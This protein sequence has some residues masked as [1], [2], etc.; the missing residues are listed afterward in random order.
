MSKILYTAQA[1]V[2]GGRFNGH[3]VTSDGELEVDIRIPKDLGG[4]GEGTNPEQLFA[5]GYASCFENAV[6]SAARRAK[7][8]LGE[9]SV[10]S[11]VH[12]MPNQER[13]FALGV[14]LDV[15]I[16]GLDDEQAI[17]L[18]RA[19]HKVCPYSNAIKGNVEVGLT[20]NGQAVEG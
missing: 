11:K 18:V 9:T 17:E 4:P 1:K 16:P 3:G 8:E 13:G 5:V 14:D 6:A 15:T 12:L 20:A 19:A 2:S 7:L 10:D